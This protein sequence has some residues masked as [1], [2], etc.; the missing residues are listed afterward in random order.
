[1]DKIEAVAIDLDGVL[2]NSKPLFDKIDI[3]CSHLTNEE[4]WAYFDENL[5][6]L[7]PNKWCVELVKLLKLKYQ[8]VFITSRSY[9]CQSQTI[10]GINQ[11]LNM[12]R[13]EYDIKMRPIDDTTTPSAEVKQRLLNE[14]RE[15]YSFK[16]AIDD[17]LSNCKMFASNGIATLQALSCIKEDIYATN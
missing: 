6:T 16:L 10:D 8:I 1:M 11:A 13:G 3:E 17:D 5:E 7:E 9:K 12:Q 2:F 15:L 4:K 14:L